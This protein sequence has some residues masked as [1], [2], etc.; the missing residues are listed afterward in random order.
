[1]GW[2]LRS[3]LDSRGR[4]PVGKFIEGLPEE[5]RA[6]VRARVTFLEE[7]GN[8]LREPHSESLGGGLFELRIRSRRILY[9]F[10]P[11]RRIVLLHGFTKKTQKIPK[12]EVN[13]AYGRME[14]VKHE[15]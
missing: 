5:D 7:V 15:N 8:A 11:G 1:M 14:E 9:C 12:R 3:Y 6:L 13:I 10:M 2:E 4:D